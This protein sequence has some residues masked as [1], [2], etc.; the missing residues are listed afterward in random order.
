MQLKYQG[1]L[2][3][4]QMQLKK[5]VEDVQKLVKDFMA[6][7]DIDH[8]EERIIYLMEVE[9]KLKNVGER[10]ELYSTR[11]KVIPVFHVIEAWKKM[12]ELY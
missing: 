3:L 2:V 9:E 5:D 6:V 1:E 8:W 10:A 4:N 7:G 11:E 12:L